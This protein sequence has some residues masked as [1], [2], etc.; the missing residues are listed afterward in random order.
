MSLASIQAIQQR[1]GGVTVT[2]ALHHVLQEAAG[3]RRIST[4][5]GHVR[6]VQRGVEPPLGLVRGARGAH[7]PLAADA[8]LEAARQKAEAALAKVGPK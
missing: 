5:H 3:S 8:L 2:A 7:N 4:I 1:A 6:F